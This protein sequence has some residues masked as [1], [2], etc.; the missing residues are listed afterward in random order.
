MGLDEVFTD[1]QVLSQDMVISAEREDRAAIRM[2]GFP[3]KL[4]DTPARLHRP[5]PEL[6]EH[7]ESVLRDIVLPDTKIE[8]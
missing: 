1:P 5:P 6:G 7:T 4:S 3:V 8:S 2:T